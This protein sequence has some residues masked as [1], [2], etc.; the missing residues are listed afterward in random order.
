MRT[1]TPGKRATWPE[2]GSENL[3]PCAEESVV[4][5]K[6]KRSD[7]QFIA[8]KRC[9]KNQPPQCEIH[10]R[11][12]TLIGEDIN[13]RLTSRSPCSLALFKLLALIFSIACSS[14]LTAASLR[15]SSFPLCTSLGRG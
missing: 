7:L 14:R 11:P 2:K 9:A 3:K 6:K 12:P 1:P 13:S 5:S 10:T 4:I 15:A 8:P